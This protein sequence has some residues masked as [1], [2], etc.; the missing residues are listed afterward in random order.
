MCTVSSTA[1]PCEAEYCP[2]TAEGAPTARFEVIG[3]AVGACQLTVTYSDGTP[4][5]DALFTYVEGPLQY[6]CEALCG[7]MA[8]PLVPRE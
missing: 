8:G 6:C 1:T 4:T 7:K 5:E 3:N 2:P